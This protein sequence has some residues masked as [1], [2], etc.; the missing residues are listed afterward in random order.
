MNSQLGTPNRLPPPV[1]LHEPGDDSALLGD[2]R[3]PPPI[4]PPP[5]RPPPTQPPR[6][7]DGHPND[8]ATDREDRGRG[9]VGTARRGRGEGRAGRGV[10]EVAGL[11]VEVPRTGGRPGKGRGERGRPGNN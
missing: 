2:R 3:P 1:P 10:V 6:R 7:E 5:I 9:Q 4:R 8:V 11:L